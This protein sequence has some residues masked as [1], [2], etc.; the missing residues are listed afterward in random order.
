[1]SMLQEEVE[2]RRKAGE[3]LELQVKRLRSRVL[4]LGVVGVVALGGLL[5]TSIDLVSRYRELHQV[6]EAMV[7]AY[8]ATDSLALS[9]SLLLQAEYRLPLTHQIILMT[10]RLG[11]ISPAE[12]GTSSDFRTDLAF[13]LHRITRLANEVEQVFGVVITFDELQEMNTVDDMIRLVERR[14]RLDT[15]SPLQFDAVD[16]PVPN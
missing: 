9:D 12:V 4:L 5:W 11:S 10:G 6:N 16:A 3:R 15:E 8:A 13:D 2:A 1:M 7:G 14:A